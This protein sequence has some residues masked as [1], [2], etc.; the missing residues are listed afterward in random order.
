MSN[1]Q[2]PTVAVESGRTLTAGRPVDLTPYADC[3]G[4]APGDTSAG[5]AFNI[6]GNTFP[7]DELPAPGRPFHLDGVTFT[8]LAA[9][10]RT[11]DNVRAVASGSTSTL[12]AWTESTSWP[13]RSGAPRTPWWSSTA[14]APDVHS[15]CGCPTSGP[16]RRPVSRNGWRCG[17]AGCSTPRHS[18]DRMAP[19]IWA[20]RVGVAVPQEAVALVLPDN[21]ALHLFAVT[22]VSVDDFAG[23]VG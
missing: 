3:I 19:A 7:A 11:P 4:V 2:S 14:T 8:L 17:A 6:W 16:R 15:G 13:P 5:G 22:L 9:D 23:G 12:P 21:P 1:S 10:G 18:Q 20:Q